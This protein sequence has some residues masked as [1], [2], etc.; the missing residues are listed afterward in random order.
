MTFPLKTSKILMYV[1]DWLYFFQCLTSFTSLPIT[2]H[3]FVQSFAV[4]SNIDKVHLINP[5][6][7]DFSVQSFLNQP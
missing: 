4:S 7:A 2:V 6:A 5:S 3:G 1:F